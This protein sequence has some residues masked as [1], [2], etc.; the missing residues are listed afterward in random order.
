M[1]TN[2]LPAASLRIEGGLPAGGMRLWFPNHLICLVLWSIEQWFLDAQSRLLPVL[3]ETP[4]RPA[5][6]VV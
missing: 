5:G 6:V 1:P 4:G 3:R 2:S